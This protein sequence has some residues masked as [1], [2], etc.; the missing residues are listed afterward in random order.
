MQTKAVLCWKNSIF[1]TSINEWEVQK[2]YKIWFTKCQQ[3]VFGNGDVKDAED[4][5]YSPDHQARCNQTQG[6][7]LRTVSPIAQRLRYIYNYV[8]TLVYC[9][10]A[11]LLYGTWWDGIAHS[12]TLAWPSTW[13]SGHFN[14]C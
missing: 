13:I 4:M 3:Y 5:K 12:S 14:Y 1:E 11:H 8:D 10:M 7:I 6:I 2:W 9:K